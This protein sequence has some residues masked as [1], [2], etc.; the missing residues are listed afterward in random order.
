MQ[1]E[2]YIIDLQSCPFSSLIASGFFLLYVN[3]V[4]WPSVMHACQVGSLSWW[5]MNGFIF[6]VVY[7]ATGQSF[8][9]LPWP[10]AELSGLSLEEMF[11]LSPLVKVSICMAL[12]FFST[13]YVLFL[14][15]CVKTWLSHPVYVCVHWNNFPSPEGL[16]GLFS[17]M[18]WSPVYCASHCMQNHY[19]TLCISRRATGPEWQP[20]TN[21][22]P[23]SSYLSPFLYLS[24]LP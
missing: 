9:Y 16:S 3:V 23:F 1:A 10:L 12:S 14:V 11:Y 19:A 17:F 8:S 20:A 5:V 22:S 24:G 18:C 13:K 7:P 2:N 21:H 4:V 15:H 6:W